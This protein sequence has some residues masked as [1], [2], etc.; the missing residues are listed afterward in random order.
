MKIFFIFLPIAML[1]ADFTLV[2]EMDGGTDGA[3]KEIIQY[4]DQ[5]NA[6]LSFCTSEKECFKTPVGEYII[7]GVKYTIIEENG[8]LTYV[9]VDK[10]EKIDDKITNELNVTS[11]SKKKKKVKPFFTVISKVSS[12]VINGI[13][14]EIWEVESEEDGRKYKENIVVTNDKNIVN[15]MKISLDILKSFGEGPYGMEIDDEIVGMLLV[16]EGYVLLSAEGFKFV[17]YDTKNIEK[18]TFKL[19]DGAVNGLENIPKMDK[20]KEIEGRKILKSLLE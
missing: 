13:K 9:N 4:K 15:A 18:S 1:F 10:V 14:G 2:Y 7:D 8:K 17:S 6:K 11:A 20:E 16:A 19:P 3:R 12:V 5:D